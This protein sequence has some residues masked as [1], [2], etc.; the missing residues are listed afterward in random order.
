MSKFDGLIGIS[1]A[2][3]K[4]NVQKRVIQRWCTGYT[5]TG[6]YSYPP[7]LNEEEC[8]KFGKT[9]VIDELALQRILKERKS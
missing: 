3:S 1:E 9:W 7:V 5:T 2:E 8:K 4:Y 6:G